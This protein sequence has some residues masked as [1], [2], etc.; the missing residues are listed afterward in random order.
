MPTEIQQIYKMFDI[1]CK[2]FIT[3]QSKITYEI[4]K[5]Q[6]KNN[7]IKTASGMW[8]LTSL[9]SQHFVVEFFLGFL[10]SPIWL[11]TTRFELITPELFNL[12]KLPLDH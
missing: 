3:S 7:S 4:L 1:V 11:L 2:C 6:I 10:I 5:Y 12:L 8:Y 9:N